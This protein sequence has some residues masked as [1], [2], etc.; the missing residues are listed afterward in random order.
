MTSQF[1]I[2]LAWL[3]YTAVGFV[4][5]YMSYLPQFDFDVFLSYGWGGTHDSLS[6]DGAWVAEFH[7]RLLEELRGSSRHISI[8]YDRE[9]SLAGDVVK[10]MLD[11]ARAAAVFVFVSTPDSERPASYCGD[12]L[13]AFSGAQH[14]GAAKPKDRTFVVQLRPFAPPPFLRPPEIFGI[15]PYRFISGATP[16]PRQDLADARSPGGIEFAR[17]A[18]HV[19]DELNSIRDALRERTTYV[20][21]ASGRNEPNVLRLRAEQKLANR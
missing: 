6:G 18:E 15:A 16:Y 2:P 1:A 13:R 20:A 19:A 3:V 5:P 11:A 17:F 10:H 8:Y 14:P 12:E 4:A 21:S 7:R 9:G